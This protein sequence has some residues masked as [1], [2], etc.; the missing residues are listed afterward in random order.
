METIVCL[1]I[2]AGLQLLLGAPFLLT[3]PWEYISRSFDLG[4]VFFF[5]WTVN[6]KFIPESVFV[7][8][9]FALVLLGLTVLSTFLLTIDR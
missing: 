7:S 6:W 4:R 5:I 8:K 9:P 3:Y 2:C 1:S